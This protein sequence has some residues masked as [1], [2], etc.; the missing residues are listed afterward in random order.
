MES[1]AILVSNHLLEV[2]SLII[3]SGV[4]FAKI[5]KLVRLPDVVLFIA[6]GI[7]LG[8]HVLNLVNIDKYPAVNQIILSFGAAYI[9]YDGG[10]EIDLKILNKVKVSVLV[11]STLGVV[12]SAFI[13]GFFAA[14]ILHIDYMYALL[15]GSVIAS[16]DPS[17]LV[18]LFKN[19]NISSK[20]KQTIISESAFNDAAGAIMTFS[21][22][23]II[24]GGSFS[25][26]SS[27]LT[28][29]KTAGGGILIGA[30]AGLIATTLV[31][32]KEIGLLKGYPSEVAV[33]T[34]A[35]AYVLADHLHFSGFMAV[36]IVGII[37]G[38][39]HM[40]KL[41]INHEHYDTHV[42]FKEVLTVILRMMIF[43]LLGTQM[44]FGILLKYWRGALLTIL[45]FIFIAR[46]VSVL[47]SVIFDRKA[48]WN[49]KEI[50][51]LMWT[52]ETGVIPAALA[53]MLVTMNIPNAQII[54][55]VT[56][57]AII[58]T[59]VFQASTAKYV[60]K[61]LKLEVEEP[62]DYGIAV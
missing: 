32:D 42:R 39:K 18:P 53:G 2:V 30:L 8:P 33:A 35:G 16:T 20:L 59:L 36:F 15:L 5:S 58:I 61:L 7:I 50:L 9:L 12:I 4:V 56:F 17:V 46:P 43:I 49:I 3:L 51:Y 26:G 47:C 62:S 55:S 29:L 6:A 27:I 14:K 28:L 19:M 48:Q 23:G 54:S 34:V 1:S 45:A 24:A 22:L 37:C 11:L 10:R 60:A 40:F 13:T 21:V 38:N 57:M 52:R 44:Q 25:L 41:N 31:S